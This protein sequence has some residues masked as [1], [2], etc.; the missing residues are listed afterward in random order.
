MPPAPKHPGSR[1]RRN[2]TTTAAN[3]PT[4]SQRDEAAPDLPQRDADDPW[5]PHVVAL[6]HDVWASGMSDEY[7][8]SDAHQLYA[9]AELYQAFWTLPVVKVRDRILLASEIRLQRVAFGLT[10]I[11][12]RRLEWQ[13]EASEAAQDR[14]FSRRQAKVA[15]RPQPGDD[16]RIALRAVR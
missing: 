9:L 15:P 13:I 10:P 1:A 5:H 11:D 3:V 6:W 7:H 2:R 16:P 4:L 14:G 8:P 12:R